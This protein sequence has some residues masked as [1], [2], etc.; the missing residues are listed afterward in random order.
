VV[1]REGRGELYSVTAA[2]TV[3]PHGGVRDHAATLDAASRACDA[4]AR[5]FETDEAHPDVY[6][7][8]ANELALL[9]SD[10]SHGRPANGLAFRMKLLLAAGIVPQLAACASCG[11]QQHLGGFSAAAGGVVCN[12]C[13]AAA[14]PLDEESYRFL[15]DALGTSLADAPDGSERVLRQV[16]RAI[17]ETAEHHAQVRLRP[18][19]AR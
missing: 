11:E 3:A 2:D 14:F 17:T 7:L 16:E 19:L 13:E 1:L 12:A 5:L 6:A 10:P 4:V 15:V 8:L 9:D 18:V